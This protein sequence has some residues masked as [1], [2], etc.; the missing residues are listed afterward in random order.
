MVYD[1]NDFRKSSKSS[2]FLH[3]LPDTSH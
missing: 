2:T 3:L 1:Q